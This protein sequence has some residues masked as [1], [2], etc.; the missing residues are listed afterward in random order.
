M[1]Y[2]D[3]KC[4]HS[5]MYSHLD[6]YAT[7]KFN[8]LYGMGDSTT[9]Y[10]SLH[11]HLW[12]TIL[13]TMQAIPINELDLHTSSLSYMARCLELLSRNVSPVHKAQPPVECQSNTTDSKGFVQQRDP[14]WKYKPPER[15]SHVATLYSLHRDATARISNMAL[16]LPTLDIAQQRIVEGHLNNLLKFDVTLSGSYNSF[17]DDL[18]IYMVLISK[19]IPVTTTSACFKLDKT[20]LTH[21]KTFWQLAT[22]PDNLCDLAF[23]INRSQPPKVLDRTSSVKRGIRS[24][25]NKQSNRAFK[26]GPELLKLI[27]SPAID[28]VDLTTDLTSRKSNKGCKFK[29]P[30]GFCS[31][32]PNT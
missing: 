20:S 21:Y 13:A 6:L 11:Q 1:D 28:V 4:M 17:S 22:I 15:N 31:P 3:L 10:S 27:R 18:D 16:K 23:G 12:K 5:S 14:A 7:N 30:K 8:D 9:N 2:V 32:L 24:L 26:T 29:K 19:A 25:L